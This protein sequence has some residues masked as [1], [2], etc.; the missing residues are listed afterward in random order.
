[1]IMLSPVAEAEIRDGMDA[2]F[3]IGQPDFTTTTATTSRSSLRSYG[4]WSDGRRFVVA[5]RTNHRVLIYNEVPDSFGDVPDVVLGQPDFDTANQGI[6]A[7]DMN[8]PI[9][10]S[11][12][13]EKLLVLDRNNNRVMV[14]NTIPQ[15]NYAPADYAIGQPDLDTGAAAV[16]ATTLNF[17]AGFMYDGSRLFIA[18]F[19]A[20]RVLIFNSLPNG[21]GAA[22]DV[23]LGQPDFLSNTFRQN[24]AGF[25]NPITVFSDRTRLVVSDQTNHR[26]LIFS[27]IPTANFTPPDIVV[28][29]PDF[30]TVTPGSDPQKL[31]FPVG[32]YLDGPSLFIVDQDNGRVIIHDRIPTANYA[33]PDR[34]LGQPNLSTVNRVSTRNQMNFP[35]NLI[36][37]GG[38]LFVNEATNGNRILAFD[39]GSNVTAADLGPQFTQGK[40][41]LGKVFS[42]PNENGAQDEGEKGLEGVKVVSDTGIYAITDSEGKYHFP[43]IETGQ[44]I[45]KLDPGTLP[46]GARITTESP[47]KTVVTEGVLTK[48]S[49]GVKTSDNA[50]EAPKTGPLLKA[51]ITQDPALLKPWLNVSA[52]RVGGKILFTFETNYAAFVEGGILSLYDEKLHELDEIRIERVPYRYEIDDRPEAERFGFSVWDQKGHRDSTAIGVIA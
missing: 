42:D 19:S 6:S 39:I 18:D 25:R 7:R 35:T 31:R 29:Q 4:L 24:Q 41:L 52:R 38:R 27:K 12:A 46:E 44:R 50:L 17:P 14:W 5:D 13:R 30:N 2:A 36:R 9:S 20:H 16:N 51:T 48:I 47:R 32:V 33:M 40:A 26:V 45:L 28:G 3:V 37:V 15:S 21:F 10:V 1:M 11:I 34:V 23:V 43:Y 22:A 49:F 8:N